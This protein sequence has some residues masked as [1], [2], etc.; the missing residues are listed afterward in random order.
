MSDSFLNHG[1]NTYWKHDCFYFSL[2]PSWGSNRRFWIPCCCCCSQ[3]WWWNWESL[4]QL[5]AAFLVSKIKT[6]FLLVIKRYYCIFVSMFRV[7][8]CW[9]LP[10]RNVFKNM[11]LI[12]LSNSNLCLIIKNNNWYLKQLRYIYFLLFL[13]TNKSN[14]CYNSTVKHVK[15]K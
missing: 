5:T 9:E 13:M 4:L 12:S 11:L 1:N 14:Y 6:D 2:T 10:F 15:I 3:C 8:S 7:S